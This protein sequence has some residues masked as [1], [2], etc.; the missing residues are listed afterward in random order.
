MEERKRERM[1]SKREKAHKNGPRGSVRF[2]AEME[3]E[4]IIIYL[5]FALLIKSC[6]GYAQARAA[7]NSGRRSIVITDP[8]FLLPLFYFSALFEKATDWVYQLID[9]QEGWKQW[10]ALSSIQIFVISFGA[11]DGW[12][13]MSASLLEAMNRDFCLTR[14]LCVAH[15]HDYFYTLVDLTLDVI[16]VFRSQVVHPSVKRATLG[17]LFALVSGFVGPLLQTKCGCEGDPTAG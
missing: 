11:E 12:G 17:P 2:R 9:S 3:E 1:R 15:I 4:F 13:K 5:F 16:S 14:L 8:I 6:C 7:A 10:P